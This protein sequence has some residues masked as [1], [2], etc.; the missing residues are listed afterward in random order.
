MISKREKTLKGRSAWV[1]LFIALGAIGLFSL[2]VALTWPVLIEL[3]VFMLAYGLMYELGKWL[4][5]R[6]SDD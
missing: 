1:F 6:P 2:Q 4:L 3:P 5:F